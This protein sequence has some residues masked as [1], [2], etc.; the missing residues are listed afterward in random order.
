M[1]NICSLCISLIV[2]M[3]IPDVVMA[4]PCPGS[5]NDPSGGFARVINIPRTATVFF[6]TGCT[7]AYVGGSNA[8]TNCFVVSNTSSFHQF[9]AQWPSETARLANPLA[10]CR[11][12]CGTA[13]SVPTSMGSTLMKPNS[14][15][16]KNDALPVE[17]MEFRID[18]QR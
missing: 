11:F 6:G 16:V 14:C 17:L 18:G 10:G 15:M 2:L 5:I 12:N 13:V 7:T 1:K 4:Q 8:P 3:W 9:E